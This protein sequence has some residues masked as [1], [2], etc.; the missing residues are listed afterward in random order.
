MTDAGETRVELITAGLIVIVLAM[1]VLGQVNNMFAMLLAGGI[2]LGSGVYQTSKGWHVSLV[3]WLVGLLLFFGGL[4]VRMFLVAL[5]P[6]NFVGIG[7]LLIGLYLVWSW[8]S[9]GRG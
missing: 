6:I 3:T 5:L 1:F 9:K 7:L 8:F 2:L 4:G